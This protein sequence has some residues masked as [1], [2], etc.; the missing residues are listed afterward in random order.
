MKPLHILVVDDNVDFAQSL[1]MLLTLEGHEVTLAYSGT[2]AIN[3]F[4]LQTFDLTFMDVRLPGKSGV[5][6]FLTIRKKHPCAKVVMM[7]AYS[8]ELLLG[9]AVEAGALAVLHKPVQESQI[10]ELLN[11]VGKD[12]LVLIA[13]GDPGLVGR[14]S[15]GLD[16]EGYQTCVATNGTEAKSVLEK[17]HYNVLILDMKGP[18]LWCIEVVLFLKQAKRQIHTLIMSGA[19]PGEVSTHLYF[20]QFV[21]TGFLVKPFDTAEITEA[22]AIMMHSREKP[23]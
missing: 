9:R 1:G 20:S 11:K 2:E 3:A 17:D 14:L 23:I 19:P 8:G 16:Q 7:T 18:L 21:V 5:E 10:T 15:R 12:N 4:D 6:S 22:I 13:D